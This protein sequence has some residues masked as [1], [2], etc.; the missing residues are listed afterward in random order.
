MNDQEE[1]QANEDGDRMNDGRKGGGHDMNPALDFDFNAVRQS[2]NAHGPRVYPMKGIMMERAEGQYVWD[3]TNTRYLDMG[4]SH[5]AVN[6]G[7]CNPK[8]V[9]A[10]RSQAGMIMHIS[11]TYYSRP[12]AELLAL[13]DEI[14]PP[15]ITRAFLSNSGTE[16]VEAALKFARACTG[17][18]EIIA[19]KGAFHGKT[20]GSL[21]TTWRIH[22]KGDFGPSVPGVNHIRFNSV[23]ELEGAVTD[24]TAAV[25]LEVVQ[26]EGGVN[27]GTGAF[28]GSV[29]RL[30]REHG[31]LLIIDEIQTGFGRCGSMFAFERFGLEPDIICMAKSVAGGFPMGITMGTERVFT[32]LQP[33]SHT[34]TFGGNPLACAAAVAAINE[35]RNR[36]LPERARVLGTRLM[37][38]LLGIDSPRIREIRG[39]GLMIAIELRDRAGPVMKGLMER[40]IL[41]L[42]SGK[43]TIRLLPPLI[44]SEEDI[45]MTVEVLSDLLTHP[46]SEN[47]E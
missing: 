26:G 16:S 31:A 11:P 17:R 37:D 24:K 45:D 2:E 30:A 1:Q 13:L 32:S 6:A 38:G 44:V 47:E 4:A 15:S 22:Y 18:E 5:G 29:Q 35:I 28:L 23:A 21:S 41:A 3:H 39:L 9:Q 12:R 36:G 25:I 33:S 46:A 19:M 8:V 10:I 20:L 42:G 7:H 14:T 27:I 34:S 43:S 40:G